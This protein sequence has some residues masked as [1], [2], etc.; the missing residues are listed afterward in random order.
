MYAVNRFL[1]G[2]KATDGDCTYHDTGTGDTAWFQGRGWIERGSETAYELH[3]H[4][5]LIRG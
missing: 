1:G 3:C 2:F 4:G 5:G